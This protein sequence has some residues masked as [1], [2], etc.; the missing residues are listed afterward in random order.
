M[1]EEWAKQIRQK[2]AGYKKPAPDVSWDELEKALAAGKAKKSRQLWLRRVAA[3][4]ALLLVAGV[5]YRSLLYDEDGH[6]PKQVS[7]ADDQPLAVDVHNDGVHDVYHQESQDSLPVELKTLAQKPAVP[8]N[9]VSAS[10]YDITTSNVD[11]DTV[12]TVVT[13]ENDQPHF[14]EGKTNPI[15]PA[16]SVKHSTDLHRQIHLS[17]RLTA[18]VYLSSAMN[19]SQIDLNGSQIEL[20]NTFDTDELGAPGAST[21]FD[22]TEQMY[23]HINHHQPI[24]L[25]FSLRYRL[26]NRW[27]LESGLSY[28]HLSSEIIT[29]TVSGTTVTEQRLN[30]LGMPLNIGYDIWNNRYFSLYVTAGGMIEKRLDADSWQFSLNGGAGA[31]YKLSDRL[32]LYVE[33]GLGYYFPNGSTTPTIYQDHPLNINLCFGLRFNLK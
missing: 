1:N 11:V 17:N 32:S 13:Q 14:F 16:P 15:E 23:Q 33:P 2:M 6:S 27:S 19:G 30:Y 20:S 22:M 3:V 24:R 9:P 26:D 29:T 8:N 10:G 5:G 18:K 7:I 31:E 12:K 4:A 25:G 28:T 21:S